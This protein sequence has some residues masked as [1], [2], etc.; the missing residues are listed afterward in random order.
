MGNYISISHPGLE[1]E[2]LHT[3]MRERRLNKIYVK[4]LSRANGIYFQNLR[5]SKTFIPFDAL[6]KIMNIYFLTTRTLGA[7]LSF[8]FKHIKCTQ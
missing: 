6:M 4:Q 7:L 8:L 2:E 1:N 5:S 3:Y